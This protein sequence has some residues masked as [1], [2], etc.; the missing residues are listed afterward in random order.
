M[1]DKDNK[2]ASSSKKAEPKK[3]ADKAAPAKAAAKKRPEPAWEAGTWLSMSNGRLGIPAFVV[4]GALAGS[5]K[6][7][8]FTEAEV[9]RKVSEFLNQTL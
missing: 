6:G 8:R 3:A 4:A 7:V 9:K 5:G 1:A 2:K